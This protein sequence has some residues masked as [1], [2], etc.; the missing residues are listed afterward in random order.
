MPAIVETASDWCRCLAD[1]VAARRVCRLASD[2]SGRG[3]PKGCKALWPIFGYF[4]LVQKVTP[5]RVGETAWAPPTNK[6]KKEALRGNGTSPSRLR[7]I[8]PFGRERG[9]RPTSPFRGDSG[10]GAGL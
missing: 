8:P 10:E 3:I 2:A 1:K 5:R 6:T 7:R 4:L 9:L